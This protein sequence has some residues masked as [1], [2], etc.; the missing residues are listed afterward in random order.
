LSHRVQGML[1][2]ARPDE[3]VLAALGQAYRYRAYE[4]SGRGL[5]LLDVA[6]AVPEAGDRATV[7]AAR[8]LAPSYVDAVRVLGNDDDNDT[9][10][11]F[12]WL[13]ASAAVAETLRQPVLGFVSD[14]HLLDFATVV[15]PSG[16]EVVD[17]RLGHYLLRW[18]KGDLTIQPFLDQDQGDLP[19]PPEELALIPAVTLLGPERLT[20]GYPLHG[21]VTAEMSGFANGASAL[22]IGTL[23][24]G[25]QGS[26]ALVDAGRL[27]ASIWD[28]A[29]R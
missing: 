14:D 18:E 8:R 25:R 21:N 16:V 17:D 11:Q 19:A 15:A 24:Y 9:F 4:L 12:A 6:V 26:L 22:G 10:E 27:D 1:V 28:R 7:R 23:D 13:A 3:A 5:W 2:R 20:G 29:V